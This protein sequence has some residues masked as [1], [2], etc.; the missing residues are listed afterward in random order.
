MSSDSKPIVAHIE[1]TAGIQPEQVGEIQQEID[2]LVVLSEE[3]F[4]AEE[5]KLLRKVSAFA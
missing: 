2:K 3:E 5:K 1:S 4:K